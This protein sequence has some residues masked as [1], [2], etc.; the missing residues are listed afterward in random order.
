MMWQHVATRMVMA[1]GMVWRARIQMMAKWTTT[2]NLFRI[3]ASDFASTV[4]SAV[5]G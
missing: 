4:F 2:P 1:S 3:L 5:A